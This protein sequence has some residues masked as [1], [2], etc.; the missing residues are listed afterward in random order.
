MA[1]DALLAGGKESSAK[2]KSA[3]LPAVEAAPFQKVGVGDS[4]RSNLVVVIR[5]MGST[6]TEIVCAVK[7]LGLTLDT[8]F[9]FCDFLSF[10]EI[11]V[12]R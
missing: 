5:S 12:R 4:H 1:S 9:S 2:D 7:G 11:L 10:R 6:A 8:D 3:V